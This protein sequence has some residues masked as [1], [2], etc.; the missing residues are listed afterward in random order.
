MHLLLRVLL[1][2]IQSWE[3]LTRSY[4]EGQLGDVVIRGGAISLSVVAKFKTSVVDQL[5][6]AISCLI[7]AIVFAGVQ[8]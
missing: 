1:C 3:V 2:G 5:L 7:C 4:L 8:L 6:S